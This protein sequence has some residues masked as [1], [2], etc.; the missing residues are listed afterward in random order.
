MRIPFTTLRYGTQGAQTWGLNF[1]RKI[2]RNSEEAVW[3]PV[4]RQF[5][6]HRVSLA[7]TLDLEAPSKR[8][9]T[10]SP[11]ALSTGSRTTRW[12]R[13]RRISA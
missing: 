5:N 4:P 11:Y 8:I 1:E 6:L 7:G 12:H 3:A 13:P 10:V 2:R 9:A